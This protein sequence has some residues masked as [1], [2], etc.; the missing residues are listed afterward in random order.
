[1]A[2]CG[3]FMEGTSAAW[4]KERATVRTFSVPSWETGG[5]LFGMNVDEIQKLSILHWIWCI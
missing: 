4:A 1:M 2:G 5:V 3:R